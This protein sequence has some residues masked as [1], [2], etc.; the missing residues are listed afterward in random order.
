MSEF[1]TR[2]EVLALQSCNYFGIEW[3]DPVTDEPC[4]ISTVAKMRRLGYIS[5]EFTE[6]FC[7]ALGFEDTQAYCVACEEDPEAMDE[8][9][10]N[11]EVP[12]E[13]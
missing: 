8:F 3:S 9:F 7:Q 6:A 1:F 10:F 5:P 12:D 11:L 2:D 13:N 4:P